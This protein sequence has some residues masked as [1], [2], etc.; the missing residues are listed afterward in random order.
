M[1]KKLLIA[2]VALVAFVNFA[3]AADVNSA[4]QAALDGIKGIGPKTAAAIIKE[5]DSGGKFKDWND[6]IKRVKGVGPKNAAKLSTG[7]LTVN[8]EPMANAPAK[9]DAK[10]DSKKKDAAGA[11]APKDAKAAATPPPPA[12]EPKT[13]KAP[14]PAKEARP[15]Q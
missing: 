13:A 2:L 4:D 15:Q 11:D 3:L 6:L 10:M 12:A 7:G 8:G 5:R 9:A 1:L 14:K